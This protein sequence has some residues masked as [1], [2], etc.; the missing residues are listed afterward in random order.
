MELVV[1]SSAADEVLEAMDD[2][3]DDVIGVI[4]KG[5]KKTSSSPSSSKSSLTWE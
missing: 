2:D 4:A 3:I 5:R 1:H